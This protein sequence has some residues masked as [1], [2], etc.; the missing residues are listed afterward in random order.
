MQNNGYIIDGNNAAILFSK[1]IYDSVSSLVENVANFYNVDANE[2]NIE[3]KEKKENEERYIIEIIIWGDGDGFSENDLENL[4]ELANSTKKKDI[5]TKKFKR[6][7]LG[8]YG[9]AFSSFQRLGN[10]VD[11]YSKIHN[12]KLLHKSIVTTNNNTQFRETEYLNNYN[13][14]PYESG[15]KLIIRN[16]KILHSI[17]MDYRNKKTN[18]DLLK[19]KL[20]YLPISDNF[21]INLCGETIKRYTINNN[22][23]KKSFNFDIDGIDFRCFICYSSFPID[24]YYYRGI[25]LKV[26][27]RII[28]WN[29]YNDIRSFISTAGSVDSRINGIITANK[30]RDKIDASRKG[31]TDNNLSLRICNELKKYISNI[32]KE[33]KS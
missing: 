31:L 5:Y 7:K 19:N 13:V 25:F 29:I 24:N 26:D 6:V 27:D 33:A 23:Y 21:R 20:S 2:V 16:C 14:I 4:R 17:F 11:I 22:C 15:S 10:H 3:F 28:D 1:H 9:I 32:Y 12:K 8:C 18:M 30:L